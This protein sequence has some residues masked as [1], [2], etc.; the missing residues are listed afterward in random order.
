MNWE[1][2]TIDTETLVYHGA[3]KTTW[4]HMWYQSIQ[5]NNF[6]NQSP[7]S[8][9]KKNIS[10]VRWLFWGKISSDGLPSKGMIRRMGPMPLQE[11]S[12][13]I[14]TWK[15]RWK[16][17]ENHEDSYSSM[18]FLVGEWSQSKSRFFEKNTNQLTMSQHCWLKPP[19]PRTIFFSI[20]SSW[21]FLESHPETTILRNGNNFH[22]MKKL[23]L[24]LTWIITLHRPPQ[25]LHSPKL[26]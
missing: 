25:K 24:W 9:W 12:I 16:S 1:I 2:F 8:R 4:F 11:S 18:G 21:R 10:P 26:T 22:L 19:I 5:A 3:V 7:K 15:N 14:N 17:N 13:I 23:S 6:R 20:H